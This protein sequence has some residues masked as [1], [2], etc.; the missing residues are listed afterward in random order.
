M[1]KGKGWAYTIARVL[2]GLIFFVFGYGY[3]FMKIPP[4][5]ASTP[6]GQMFL[7]FK[8]SVYFLPFL[9]GVE[10]TMGL[11]LL[12]GRYVPVALLV[13]APIIIQIVLFHS[14]LEPSGLPLALLNVAL[15]SFLAWNHWDKY[16]VLFED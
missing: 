6:M 2:L 16:R 15:A 14:F 10:G 11:L 9:K 13:L 8:A 4:V 12:T 7:G 1:K 5:D 3:F